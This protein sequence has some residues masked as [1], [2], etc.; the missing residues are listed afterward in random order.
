MQPTAKKRILIAYFSHS[1]NTRV[2]ANQIYSQLGGDIFEIEAVNKY[3]ADYDT[4]VEQ[5][6]KELQKQHRPKLVASVENMQEYAV[7]FVGYPNWWGT[8]PMPVA[9]FLT[10]YSFSGKTITPFCTNEGSQ[11]GNSV[12]DIT[13]LCPGAKVVKGL[14]IRGSQVKNAQSD[15]SKW[16]RELGMIK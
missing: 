15:V 1:G 8:I 6:K 13:R 4:V 16:L 14:P 5:V 2:V 3:P 9:T 12:E 10:E 7:V 11:L